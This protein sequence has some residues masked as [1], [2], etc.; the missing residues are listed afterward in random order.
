VTV[1]PGRQPSPAL[2]DRRVAF[3]ETNLMTAPFVGAERGAD[4]PAQPDRQCSG[5]VCGELIAA[6]IVL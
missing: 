5:E 2:A 1:A 6:P 4:V 3:L